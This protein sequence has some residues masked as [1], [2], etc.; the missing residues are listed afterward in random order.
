MKKRNIFRLFAFWVVV[1]F[2]TP[3]VTWAQKTLPRRTQNPD[4]QNVDSLKTARLQDSLRNS[5][6]DTIPVTYY[7][8]GSERL[9]LAYADTNINQVFQQYDPVR[10]LDFGGLNLGNTGSPALPLLIDPFRTTGLNWGFHAFDVYHN[11]VDSLPFFGLG[12][13]LTDTYFSFKGQT[14]S[15]FRAKFSRQFSDGFQFSLKYLKINQF[16]QFLSQK[17]VISSL[18]TGIQ[19]INPKGRYR[20]Y[21]TMSSNNSRVSENGGLTTD[22]LFF[23]PQFNRPETQPIHLSS[24]Q[25]HELKRKYQFFHF[26]KLGNFKQGNYLEWRHKSWYEKGFY[27][28]F[29]NQQ[30]LDTLYYGDFMTDGRGVRQYF[31]GH[32]LG[33]ELALSFLGHTKDSLAFEWLPT[34]GLQVVRYEVNQEPIIKKETQVALTGKWDMTLKKIFQLSANANFG[35][36]GNSGDYLLNGQLKINTGKAGQWTLFADFQSVTPFL[37]SQNNYISRV[38]V[39]ENSFEKEFINRVGGRYSL[40]KYN[41][42]FTTRFSLLTNYIYFDHQ[43]RPVQEAKT[44]P[45]LQ[46]S[47]NK[48]IQLVGWG[49][50]SRVLYQKTNEEIIRRPKFYA[51]EQLSW[52][53]D[54]FSSA[55]RL[56]MG[57]DYRFYSSWS[58]NGYNPVI[59]QFVLQDD[60]QM[61]NISTFDVFA[62]FKVSTFRFFAKMENL[63]YYWDKRVFFQTADYPQFKPSF[64]MGIGWIFRD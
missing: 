15:V 40:P 48:N 64:R 27:K 62:N 55:L 56:K 4:N 1:F 45:L 46:L 34:T 53:G 10:R 36:V 14:N 30:P 26:Y 52:E 24:A 60:F 47:A 50:N 13:A 35:L 22:S 16:G 5:L 2:I 21:L 23:V 3:D 29:D 11:T 61:D 33:T 63:Q 6:P 32:E 9:V 18:A 25:T 37:L 20:F 31:S 43:S 51:Q 44:I 58:P 17:A 42:N 7:Y 57:V 59:G 19:Y 39:W 12:R 8:Q 38:S 49:L 28:F 54:L 41:F